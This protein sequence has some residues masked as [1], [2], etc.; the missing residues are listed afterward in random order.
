[1]VKETDFLIFKGLD[2]ATLAKLVSIS[3]KNNCRNGEIVFYE[4]DE[5]KY[6]YLLVSGGIRVYK[7]TPKGQEIVLHDMYAPS[8]VGEMAN[9]EN[10]PFPATAK[11]I[12]DS[13]VIK[14]DFEKFS[15]DVL[16][17]KA[18]ALLIIKSLSG[19]LK[20]LEGFI[21]KEFTKTAEAK[22]AMLIV[23]SPEIFKLTKHN[24]VAKILNITPETLSRT[25]TKLKN[26]EIISIDGKKICV[27]NE[28][29]LKK[30]YE[31]EW[32]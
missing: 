27:I 21:D 28:L 7:T 17:D 30:I 1:M 10:M 8:L 31:N 26:D 13:E 32:V 4:K 19:K 11:A 23:E 29:A 14:I 5:P 24:N 25:L 9:F 3:V 16:S 18:A 12:M 20:W 2:D 15:S 6:M 22:V